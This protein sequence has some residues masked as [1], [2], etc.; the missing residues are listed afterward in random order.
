M[1]E[2]VDTCINGIV[3]LYT[4]ASER[5]IFH[6]KIVILV[7]INYTV[8][9]PVSGFA[10]LNCI[11]VFIIL[12]LEAKETKCRSAI[13]RMKGLPFSLHLHFDVLDSEKYLQQVECKLLNISPN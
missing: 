7:N 11:S 13:K 4:R 3:S 1:K 10:K 8:I 9:V 2:H 6:S 5:T 12:Q